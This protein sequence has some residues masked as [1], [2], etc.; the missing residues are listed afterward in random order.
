VLW[1]PVLVYMAALFGVS[2]LHEVPSIPGDTGGRF[3][4]FAAY[5]GLAMVTL[6]ALASGEWSGVR[7]A[8]VIGA[9]AIASLYGVSDE[10]HQKFVP[11]RTFDVI[12]MVADALGAIGAASVVWVCSI[13]RLRS[14][15]RHVL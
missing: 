11:G 13:I 2:S 12:D 14:K 6:R 9:V 8:T 7:T 10:Y 4:H 1:L 15:T 3:V 5:G